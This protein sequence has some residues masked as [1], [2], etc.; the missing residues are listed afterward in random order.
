MSR[1]NGSL[2]MGAG[3]LA[4]VLFSGPAHAG[5][6][7]GSDGSDGLFNPLTNTVV[8]LSLAPTATWDTPGTG[9][10]VYDPDLW[11]VVFKFTDIDIPAG[12][13]V[14][15]LNH[16]SGAP[17]VWLAQGD[18]TIAGTVSVSAGGPGGFAGGRAG[19]GV[20]SSQSPGFGPGGGQL[21]GGG[22]GGAGGSHTTQGSGA[23][24]GAAYG[25]EHL[26]PLIGGS[27]GGGAP[28]LAGGAGGGAIA[29]GSNTA[30]SLIGAG[31]IRAI[32]G[33]GG[34]GGSGAGSGGSIRLVAPTVAGSAA[35]LLA[36]GETAG[37]QDGGT[38]R[39]RIDADD[40]QLTGSSN[41]NY[42]TDQF[43][44]PV[45]PPPT[46]PTLKATLV[47][48]VSVPDDPFAGIE[49][50]DVS[51]A[52]PGS[53]TVDIEATNIPAGTIV[54]VHVIPGRGQ[55]FNVTSTPLVDIGG[56]L[57]TATASIPDF[58]AGRVELQLRAAW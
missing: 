38:G 4:A 9:D 50:T 8:D 12:V 31:S 53:V 3:L 17:V 11:A 44:I 22:S 54:T 29:I 28:T 56:G 37:G 32:G 13:T 39:I 19:T 15:F 30:I 51:I 34:G 7:S 42:S 25:N 41:P 36:N 23:A 48:G 52:N 26:L 21:T 2:R 5:F 55:R 43:V 14:T 45:F 20:S 40:V 16:P 24:A 10:G 46:Y 35:G 58:P 33:G 6:D 18:V 57:L 1:R 47:D 49:T 27:G